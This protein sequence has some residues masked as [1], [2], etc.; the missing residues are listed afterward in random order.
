MVKWSFSDPVIEDMY[1]GIDAS[2]GDYAKKCQDNDG[3]I[4]GIGPKCSR[5]EEQ[6][7]RQLFQCYFEKTQDCGV[8]FYQQVFECWVYEGNCGLAHGWYIPDGCDD[9]AESDYRD[10]ISSIANECECRSCV[11]GTHHSGG[12]DDDPGSQPTDP[13]PEA[14][15]VEDADEPTI[16]KLTSNS[17]YVVI[18]RVFG[19]YVVAGNVIWIGNE[20]E[21]EVTY[22]QTNDNKVTE[23]TDIVTKIDFLVGLCVGPMTGILRVWMNDILILNNAIELDENGAPVLTSNNGSIDLNAASF[24]DSEYNLERLAVYRPTL[25]FISGSEAQHVQAN[26]A[27]E[28]GFGRVPA[29]RG[30]TGVLFRDVDV[31]LFNSNS[32][33]SFRFE[34]FSTTPDTADPVLDTI[35]ESVDNSY[36]TV[37]QRTRIAYVANASEDESFLYDF[38]TL[39]HKYSADVAAPFVTLKSGYVW[40]DGD[41]VD[42]YRNRVVASL[43][44]IAPASYSDS[45]VYYDANVAAYELAL[46]ADSATN[47]IAV[48]SFD[49]SAETAELLTAY[50]TSAPYAV[51]KALVLALGDFI[52]YVQFAI[53]GADL[54]VLR[55]DVLSADNMLLDPH[56]FTSHTV[57]FGDLTGASIVSLVRDIADNSFVLMFSNGVSAKVST[58]FAIVW[59]GTI[60]TLSLPAESATVIADTIHYF[61]DGDDTIYA[62]TLSTG[63]VTTYGS[64]VTSITGA[65]YY[66][67]RT[68][69]LLYITAEGLSRVFL[70]RMV[71]NRLAFSAILDTLAAQT[72]VSGIFNTDALDDQYLDG[73]MIDYKTNLAG[74]MTQMMELYQV[75]V[76][77]DGQR[78]TVVSLSA[79]TDQVS[80]DQSTDVIADSLKTSREASTSVVNTV[81]AT[82]VAI[83]DTGLIEDTQ[84][85]T[86][87]PDLDQDDVRELLFTL[88]LLDNPVSVREKLEKVLTNRISSASTVSV[89]VLSKMLGIVPQDRLTINGQTYRV[90][91]TILSPDFAMQ[92]QGA[93][94]DKSNMDISVT[95]DAA[96]LSTGSELVRPTK[97]PVYRPVALFLP[98]VTNEDVTRSLGGSQVVYTGIDAPEREIESTTFSIRLTGSPLYNSAA[99]TEA[100][101]SGLVTVAP[102]DIYPQQFLTDSDS[103]LTIAFN[104]EETVDFLTTNTLLIVGREYIRF[105]QFNDLGGGIVEFTALSRGQYGTES[106]MREHVVGEHAYL[107]TPESF[108][109][110]TVDPTYTVGLEPGKIIYRR[111]L[112]AGV[113]NLSFNV[114]V[115]GGSVR[116]PG[117]GDVRRF[118][119]GGD[120]LACYIDWKYRRA[121]EVNNI[122]N[123]G[124]LVNDFIPGSGN[125]F[126]VFLLAVPGDLTTFE[127]RVVKEKNWDADENGAY[128]IEVIPL[129]ELEPH[130]A[131]FFLASDPLVDPV[132]LAI[133]AIADDDTIVGRPTF[134][135]FPPGK[136]PELP[137]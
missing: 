6:G 57:V 130:N 63:E 82:F 69:S 14:P 40:S 13:D 72:G 96:Q 50:T 55:Y 36:I 53:D 17:A 84:S 93:V 104:H 7:K 73:F 107:Y 74:I 86:L 8:Q 111:P 44:S 91:S 54:K 64:L 5:E 135:T 116:P 61:A 42:P 67:S 23:Y 134:V 110:M 68:R 26:I 124:E 122:D 81:T 46:I 97:H 99:H 24:V 120:D 78:L 101:H 92:V 12:N 22:S 1:E 39:E 56:V 4:Q 37:D 33:P 32:F 133:V 85:A 34:V 18:P 132:H 123:C 59:R 41:I 88:K 119:V 105:G 89:S 62:L 128:V 127:Q 106:Y 31:Q 102:L 125:A 95:L 16:A 21:E 77:D 90:G 98:N 80:A 113:P 126:L 48:V 131:T 100:L 66:D 58:D 28:E 27:T 10:C 51:E 94:Y 112:P 75:A 71:P 38:D 15:V 76:V 19:R 117:P 114:S 108:K 103:V 35:V 83:D 87:N 25:E 2:G 45:M 65:Q 47:N 52:S 109:I 20:T 115:D 60:P 43:G 9:A 11:K 3:T 129:G 29:N 70:D 118:I 137:S 121:Y 136:Y 30:I 79:F 49:Y